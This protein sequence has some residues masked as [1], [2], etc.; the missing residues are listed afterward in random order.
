VAVL[1]TGQSGNP[2]SPHWNDQAELWAS[3]AV[4]PA[5]FTRSAVEAV[6]DRSLRLVPR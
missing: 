5:P 3:G 1:A 4:R 2:A 6:A